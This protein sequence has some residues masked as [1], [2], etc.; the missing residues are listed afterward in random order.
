MSRH[1][2]AMIAIAASFCVTQGATAAQP[3]A[4][5]LRAA[6]ELLQSS[7]KMS[8][9]RRTRYADSNQCSGQSKPVVACSCEATDSAGNCTHEVCDTVCP[10]QDKQED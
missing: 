7:K 6:T 10:G 9:I 3:P 2:L 5:P 4:D 1:L 8:Q